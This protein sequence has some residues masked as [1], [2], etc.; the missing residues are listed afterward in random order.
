MTIPEQGLLTWDFWKI[1]TVWKRSQYF[2]WTQL[3]IEL[4]KHKEAHSWVILI[5]E[6]KAWSCDL[7]DPFYLDLGNTLGG[8]GAEVPWHWGLPS[9]S[10]CFLLVSSYLFVVKNENSSSAPEMALLFPTSWP[11]IPMD[12]SQWISITVHQH[13]FTLDFHPWILSTEWLQCC[14]CGA[15]QSSENVPDP[16][17]ATL[18][19]TC[20]VALLDWKWERKPIHWIQYR[21][22]DWFWHPQHLASILWSKNDSSSSSW[23]EA[24]KE[25]RLC[26]PPR[27]M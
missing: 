9:D 11:G 24:G 25:K 2:D 12:P 26:P 6:I 16:G 20:I 15:R 3:D 17:E 21:G 8:G 19:P 18:V 1:R 27:T 22:D 7:V 13:H 5:P 14:K 4:H 23:K 10:F